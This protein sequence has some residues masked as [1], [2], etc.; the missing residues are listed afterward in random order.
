M[1]QSMLRSIVLS[2][3]DELVLGQ[4]VDTNS[5]WI[6]QQLASVGTGVV[7]H[8]TVPDDHKAIEQAMLES[9]GRCDF[10]IISGGIGPTEDDLTRQ[11]LAAVMNEPL[12]LNET[13]MAKLHEFF[14]NR[15]RPMPETNKIQAMIPRGATMIEN[16]AGTAAGIDATLYRMGEEVLKDDQAALLT[17]LQQPVLPMPPVDQLAGR[18]L[19]RVLTKMGKVTREQVVEALSRQKQSGGL[20][21]EVLVRLG[22]VRQ[23]DVVTALAAQKGD[24]SVEVPP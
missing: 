4:T 1:I 10:L 8:L 20:I 2:I 6:S 5:A 23:A 21:G 12:E 16:T 17:Q 9:V 18:P 7:A 15:G 14:K 13:W 3:G 19:G 24:A 22:Y 11:A